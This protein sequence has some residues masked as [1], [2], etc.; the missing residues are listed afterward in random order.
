MITNGLCLLLFVV[1]IVGCGNQPD[2][3]S[4][5]NQTIDQAVA[6]AGVISV[7]E[8]VRNAETGTPEFSVEGVVLTA[9]PE[10]Q[11]LTII[12]LKA[13]KECGL[14]DC[15]LYMPVRWQGGMPAKEAIIVVTG[16]IE[17]T[18]AGLIFVARELQI[19]E[20]TDSL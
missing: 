6:T 3:S 7:E 13:Y 15:C 8:A 11:L 9:T 1:I 18:D 4:D 5:T 2:D 16:A 12:G 20:P 19:T 10:D 14:S 17:A